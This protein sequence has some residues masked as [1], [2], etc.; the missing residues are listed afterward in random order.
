MFPL[1]QN[2][3]TPNLFSNLIEITYVTIVWGIV[4]HSQIGWLELIYILLGFIALWL[5][6]TH[7]DRFVLIS[8]IIMWAGYYN[9]Y[10]GLRHLVELVPHFTLAMAVG[11]TFF[12]NWIAKHLNRKREWAPII[13]G[14]SSMLLIMGYVVGH[15]VIGWRSSALDY[16]RYARQIASLVPRNSSILGEM[17]WWWVL[18]ERSFTADYYLS[19]IRTA[20]PDLSA[21]NIVEMVMAERQV[22]VVLLDEYF[23]VREYDNNMDLQLALVDYTKMHCKSVGLVEDYG[24]GVETGGV[25]IKRTEVFACGSKP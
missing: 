6:R 25:R 14:S 12:G 17:S 10:K 19:L 22:D 16:N 2:L 21:S 7:A 1:R 9:P 4:G 5:R 8:W 20:R 3:E 13:I 15:L 23:H 24:Y 11:I 18:R